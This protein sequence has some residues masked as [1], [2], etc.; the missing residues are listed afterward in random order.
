MEWFSAHLSTQNA[1]LAR[2][3]GMEEGRAAR[4]ATTATPA[5]KKTVGATQAAA[6]PAP[7]K[8]AAANNAATKKTRPGCRSG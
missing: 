4:G 2:R 3:F 1:K 6:T 5:A 7:A 8:K